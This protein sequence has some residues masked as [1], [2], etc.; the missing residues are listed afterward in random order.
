MEGKNENGRK[1]LRKKKSSRRGR[2]KIK[3]KNKQHKFTIIGANSAGL[4]AK[5]ESLE[6]I[7][8]A[9]DA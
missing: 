6:N 3:N 8:K 9:N 5:I 2:G 1:F 7:V 4:K